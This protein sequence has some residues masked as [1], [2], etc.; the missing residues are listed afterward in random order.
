M[1]VTINLTQN[2]TIIPGGYNVN[3]VVD[4]AT[5]ISK[6]V[7]VVDVEFDTFRHVATPYD[8]SEYPE[9]KQEAIDNGLDFYRVSEVDVA[10]DNVT[11][12]TKYAEYTVNRVSGLTRTYAKT[13]SDFEGTYTY[14][15]TGGA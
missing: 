10:Y 1:I 3:T 9:T 2:N 7:F 15:F 4:S 5:N 12:A 8:M 6:N 14:S 11:T 13:I